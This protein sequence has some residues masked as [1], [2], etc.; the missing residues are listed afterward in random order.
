M[1]EENKKNKS[2]YI[3]DKVTRAIFLICALIAVVSLVL[4]IGF[5]FYK[6][7]RPFLQKVNH[8]FNL[9]LVLNG[10]QHQKIKSMV[11]YQ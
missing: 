2:K 10:I 5:V 7:L 9:F 6:G 1:V 4:I 8:L 11:Y 3:V